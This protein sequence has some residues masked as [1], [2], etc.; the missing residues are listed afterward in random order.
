M[1]AAWLRWSTGNQAAGAHLR[2]AAARGLVDP[3]ALEAPKLT[4][5]GTLALELY[6]IGR[7]ESGPRF[8]AVA[9]AADRVGWDVWDAWAM[10]L[11]VHEEVE[12][13][14]RGSADANRG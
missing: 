5:T 10:A 1:I 3:T 7:S 11:G 9:A 6:R 8:E 2:M 13:E 12:R 14:S 4:P